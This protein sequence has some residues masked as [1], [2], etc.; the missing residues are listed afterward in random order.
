MRTDFAKRRIG[1]PR[2]HDGRFRG[3][4]WHPE[5]AFRVYKGGRR[6]ARNGANQCIAQ[7]FARI[8]QLLILQG[9]AIVEYELK[10]ANVIRRGTVG[11][12]AGQEARWN[13]Q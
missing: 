13:G 5:T 9:I 8:M 7:Y 3:R 2:T 11:L 4:P 10:C 6:R 1:L 12:Q